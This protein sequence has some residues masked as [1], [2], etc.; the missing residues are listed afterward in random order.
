[1]KRFIL[2]KRRID[3]LAVTLSKQFVFNTFIVE[4][5]MGRVGGRYEYTTTYDFIGFNAKRWLKVVCAPYQNDERKKIYEI[6]K[7]NEK[8]RKKIASSAGIS[9]IKEIQ[10]I[11]IEL[12]HE[13]N[14]GQV[15][16]MN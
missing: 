8:G 11:I 1:M 7:S 9:M 15:S 12:R 5:G 16:D 13:W 14:V 6:M 10:L 2:P 3:S 4:I